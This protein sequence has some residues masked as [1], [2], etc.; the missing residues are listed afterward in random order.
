[1]LLGEQNVSTESTGGLILTRH[2][3]KYLEKNLLQC[4]FFPS[5]AGW[6]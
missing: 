4:N 3:Q 1:V 2:K 5:E 6:D